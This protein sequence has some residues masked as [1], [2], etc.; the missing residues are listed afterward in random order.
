MRFGFGE[1]VNPGTR[2]SEVDL[3]TT[4]EDRERVREEVLMH[5]QV[6]SIIALC[7]PGDGVVRFNWNITSV[8][9]DEHYSDREKTS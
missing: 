7:H 9:E 1:L 4:R 6:Q 5:R 3:E 8:P 2:V